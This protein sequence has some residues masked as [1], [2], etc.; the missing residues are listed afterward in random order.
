ML[1]SAYQQHV[2]LRDIGALGKP[3][4]G[5]HKIFD[6]WVEEKRELKLGVKIIWSRIQFITRR[7]R[8]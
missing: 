7:H 6:D 5:L 8:S 1:E 3:T 2:K 4:L